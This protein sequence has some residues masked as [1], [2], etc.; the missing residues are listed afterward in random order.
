MPMCINKKRQEIISFA[1][2]NKGLTKTEL[3]DI[4]ECSYPTLLNK[5]KNVET[6]RLGEFDKLCEVLE[7]QK[8][9]P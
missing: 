5:L 4:L 1:M 3:A 6:F 7:I 9:K 8:Y 2:Y